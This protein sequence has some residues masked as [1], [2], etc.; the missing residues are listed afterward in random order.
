MRVVPKAAVIILL[1]AGPMNQLNFASAQ[2][3]PEAAMF[4]P[5]HVVEGIRTSK[6]DC[7]PYE[8][9]DTAVFVTAAGT[10]ACIRYYASGLKNDR[11]ANPVTMVWL[12]G[13]VLGPSG[14]NADKRQSGFG[15]AEMVAL[16]AQVSRRF[17]ICLL[18]T[19]PSPRD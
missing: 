12:N 1:A 18:Y 11:T 15:P 2:S 17:G 8:A 13:D 6:E 3:R 9:Q 19:S 5:D 4:N 10:S 16:E 14:K 7:A